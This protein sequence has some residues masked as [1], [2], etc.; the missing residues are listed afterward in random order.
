MLKTDL[1]ELTINTE[2]I[3]EKSLAELNSVLENLNLETK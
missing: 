2:L 1:T 3:E